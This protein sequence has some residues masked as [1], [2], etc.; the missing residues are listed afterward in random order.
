MTVSTD[1]VPQKNVDE[2]V[3]V[4]RSEGIDVIGVVCHVSNEKQ[5]SNLI[6]QTVQVSP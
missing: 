6:Q 4:L 1:S 2:A 3:A 5:R